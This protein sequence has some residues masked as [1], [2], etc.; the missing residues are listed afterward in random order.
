MS[1]QKK[2][3]TITEKIDADEGLK[4][5]RKILT[6][7][8]LI[9]LLISFSDA[10]VVEANTFLVKISFGNQEGISVLFVLAVFILLI[11][12]YNYARKYHDQLYKLWSGRMIRHGFFFNT[13]PYEQD[14]SGLVIDLEPKN[15]NIEEI[16]YEGGNW[17]VGYHCD[18]PFV[19]KILYEWDDQQ[20]N[21]EEKIWVGWKNY[22]KVLRLEFYFQFKSFLT[23]RENLD[24]LAPYFLGLTA[25][26][27]YFFNKQFQT[28]LQSLIIS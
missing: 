2:E 18:F 27:S 20:N 13:N 23:H 28:V 5:K 25:I 15:I 10:K 7:T 12:Y 6:I 14:Y 4:S 3:L 9:L 22:F 8:A 19:R 24:I 21:Y 17:G 16:K 11:R 26:L 1:E